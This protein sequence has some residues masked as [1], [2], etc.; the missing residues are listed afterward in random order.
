MPAGWTIG[1]LHRST[2][3]Q[4]QQQQQQG[5]RAVE[6]PMDTAVLSSQ[7]ALAGVAEAAHPLMLFPVSAVTCLAVEYGQL[8]AH[9]RRSCVQQLKLLLLTAASGHF[10]L[11]QQCGSV[12]WC[13]LVNVDVARALPGG[14]L[15]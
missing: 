10:W 2:E 15:R 4:G 13:D 1:R 6:L 11:H 14:V 12:Q 8:A 5:L 3:Q 9:N 7:F